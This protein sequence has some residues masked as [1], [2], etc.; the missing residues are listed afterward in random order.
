MQK[1]STDT[2]PTKSRAKN[3]SHLHDKVPAPEVGDGAR[4]PRATPDEPEEERPLR[5]GE[6]LHHLPEPLDERRG[7]LHPL[8]GGDRLQQVQRDVRASAHLSTAKA[9]VSRQKTNKQKTT[10][11]PRAA[12]D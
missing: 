9:E 6:G 10:L 1:N 11:E 7:R 3:S 12:F 2:G 8:V 5:V 4:Q